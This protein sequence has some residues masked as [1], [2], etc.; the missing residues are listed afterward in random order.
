M[1]SFF[2]RPCRRRAVRLAAALTLMTAPVAT[3][4]PCPPELVAADLGNLALPFVDT[5]DGAFVGQGLA[6]RI[7]LDASGLTLAAAGRHGLADAVDLDLRFPGAVLQPMSTADDAVGSVDSY[8]LG[9]PAASSAVAYGRVTA[10]NFYPGL[11]LE[12][13]ASLRR[14]W[15]HIDAAVAADLGRLSLGSSGDLAVDGDGFTVSADV[16][17]STSGAPAPATRRTVRFEAVALDLSGREAAPIEVQSTL[18][19]GRLA[20]TLPV[21]PVGPVR[22]LLTAMLAPY[23]YPTDIE[24]LADGSLVTVLPGRAALGS[25]R[26]SALVHHVGAD[27]K[28]VLGTS[29]LESAGDLDLR[30]VGVDG[31]GRLHFAGTHVAGTNGDGK[32]ISPVLLT[33][34]PKARRLRQSGAAASLQG[35]VLDDVVVDGE[36]RP[37]VLGR[38]PQGF[39]PRPADDTFT[40]TLPLAGPETPVAPYVVA[41]LDPTGDQIVSSS[42]FPAPAELRRLRAWVDC[43]GVVHFG[44][45]VSFAAMS[46]SHT[47]DLDMTSTDMQSCARIE[48]SHGFGALC[49]KARR[50]LTDWTYHPWNVSAGDV[51]SALVFLLDPTDPG[52]TGV[53]DHTRLNQLED[54]QFG[55]LFFHVPSS[56]WDDPGGSWTHANNWAYSK[57]ELAVAAAVYHERWDSPLFANLR[58]PTDIDPDAVRAVMLRAEEF[59]ANS[60]AELPHNVCDED[61]DGDGVSNFLQ[62]NWPT[63]FE[64]QV[65]SACA[66]AHGSAFTLESVTYDTWRVGAAYVPDQTL[67]GASNAW[68]PFYSPYVGDPPVPTGEPGM[69]DTHLREISRRLAV[70]AHLPITAEIT[71]VIDGVATTTVRQGR[72]PAIHMD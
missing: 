69:S 53:S 8:H 17:P 5:G 61:D 13:R 52:A 18:Q 68:W 29:T 58:V 16:L 30:G 31:A 22:L 66:A 15:L 44:L 10:E 27:G 56:Q 35:A 32:T 67:S 20:F 7:E 14:L 59:S 54:N 62:T 12:V 4:E 65:A 51:P 1:T 45:P 72:V 25:D 43:H 26:R 42:V 46:A 71:T 41:T 55:D 57:A 38:A 34:D 2:S 40:L 21:Q 11:G 64:Y 36:G 70:R 39:E 48:E 24:R 6:G 49:W 3:A 50:N 60:T 28:T 63:P 47:Y 9:S 19:R 37:M 33:V 23:T